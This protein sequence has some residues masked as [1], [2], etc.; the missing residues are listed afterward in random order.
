LSGIEDNR[1][2]LGRIDVNVLDIDRIMLDT[3]SFHEGQVVIINREC[4]EWPARDSNDTE[5]VALALLDIDD[6]KRR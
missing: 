6:R 2:T 3:I 4:E 5:P 1:N